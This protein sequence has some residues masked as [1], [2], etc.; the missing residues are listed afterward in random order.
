MSNVPNYLK[1]YADL[2]A[3]NPRDAALQW[4][5]DARYGLFLHYGL[6]SLMGQHE[7]VQYR[8]R[9]PV[10]LTRFGR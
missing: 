1:D 3:N 7:W 5:K 10:V 4:F 8:Q 9:I 6:Y 2:Y